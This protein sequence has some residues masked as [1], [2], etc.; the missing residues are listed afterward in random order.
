MTYKETKL[1]A[2]GDGDRTVGD[3]T[4]NAEIRIDAIHPE[5]VDDLKEDF[6]EILSNVWDLD[7]RYVHVMTGEEFAAYTADDD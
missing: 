2:W 3:G 6:K 1:V 5:M 4:F 7:T